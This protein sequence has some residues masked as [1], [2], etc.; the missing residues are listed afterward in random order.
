MICVKRHR[1]HFVSLSGI[2]IYLLLNQEL[3]RGGLV[4]MILTTL[5]L[6]YFVNFNDLI[7][8]LGKLM[9]SRNPL[10]MDNYDELKNL[11]Q[12]VDFVLKFQPSQR[13]IFEMNIILIWQM[14]LL[15]YI[16]GGG[17]IASWCGHY[18][19]QDMILFV[20]SKGSSLPIITYNILSLYFIDSSSGYFT[21]SLFQLLIISLVFSI[22]YSD[23]I[24]L[25]KQ[26]YLFE[27]QETIDLIA[28]HDNIDMMVADYLIS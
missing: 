6:I 2:P 5:F 16:E 3:N 18:I 11:D 7:K 19:I 10:R 15:L 23:K 1:T 9:P 28:H 26:N 17:A 27:H 14:L 12:I 22:Q 13:S 21:M 20:V 8:I 4:H 24:D 25:E